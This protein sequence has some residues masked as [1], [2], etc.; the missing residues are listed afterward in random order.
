MKTTRQLLINLFFISITVGCGTV[1][2]NPGEKKEIP[3]AEEKKDEVHPGDSAYTENAPNVSV[4]TGSVVVPPYSSSALVIINPASLAACRVDAPTF[5]A[6]PDVNTIVRFTIDTQVT[7]ADVKF[8]F[9]N[10]TN[11]LE[12]N[13]LNPI[14]PGV[15]RIYA[16]SYS[17]KKGCYID[18]AITA[19]NFSTKSKITYNLKDF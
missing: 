17:V 13:P 12:R 18:V 1:V 5:E 2:G 16:L 3:N 15:Y 8:Y 7:V 14:E 19:D 9:Y 6:T 11:Y 4:S 10:G